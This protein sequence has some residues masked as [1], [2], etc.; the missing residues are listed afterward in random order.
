MGTLIDRF[1]EHDGPVRGVS[2]HSSQPLFVS[3]GE[4]PSSSRPDPGRSRPTAPRIGATPNAQKNP[5]SASANNESDFRIF[6]FQARA[7]ASRS[8]YDPTSLSRDCSHAADADDVSPRP[9][10]VTTTRLRFGT[11]S[12]AG[13]STPCWGTWITSARCSSTRSTRGS[14]PRPTTRPFGSGTGS[15]AAASAS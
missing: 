6:S 4:N 2:F 12:C 7:A 10:Q 9:T 11:T 5:T 15:P 14:S 8:P 1:D 3:G 13:A